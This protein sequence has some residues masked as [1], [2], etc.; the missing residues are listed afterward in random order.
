MFFNCYVSVV[1]VHMRIEREIPTAAWRELPWD[2]HV[3]R[4]DNMWE[5]WLWPVT[6]E[7]CQQRVTVLWCPHWSGRFIEST[8]S[9]GVYYFLS[10]TLSVCLSVCMS[11]SPSVTV[12]RASF[13]FLDGIEPFFWPSVLHVA[14]YKTVF[15]DFWFRPPKPQNLH[16]IAYKLACMADRQ[17]MFGPTRGF[18]GWPI[19]CNHAKC[20][21]ADPCCHGNGILANLGYFFTKK[22]IS[23]LVCQIDRTCL[24]LP[25]ETTRG[26]DLCCHGNDICA[27]RGV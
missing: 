26:A 11:V 24:G 8:P 10:L 2:T 19:Q 15:F 23:R 14:L 18:W 16:K 12:L 25:G 6:R 27:R 17:K 3:E 9:L 22:P 5:A 4:A 20:L 13:L 7:C 1:A 21:G